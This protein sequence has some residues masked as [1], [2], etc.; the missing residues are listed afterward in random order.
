[1]SVARDPFLFEFLNLDGL[2]TMS[3]ESSSD[4]KKQALCN[5]LLKLLEEHLF[6]NASFADILMR[7]NIVATLSK[8]FNK[9]TE[10][11]VLKFLTTLMSFD[12]LERPNLSLRMQLKEQKNLANFL[13]I[14]LDQYGLKQSIVSCLL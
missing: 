11:S 4:P 9:G 1:M 3:G 5:S 2:L 10:T 8:C 6:N 7:H 13:L 14:H 12:C